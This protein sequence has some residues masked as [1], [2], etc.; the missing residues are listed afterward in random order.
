MPPPLPTPDLAF[1]RHTPI[2]DTHTPSL[3]Q[4]C[5]AKADLSLVTCPRCLQQGHVVRVC[6]VMERS[7]GSGPV[8][9]VCVCVPASV[10]ACM[11][12]CV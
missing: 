7:C 2:H 9:C 5:P 1:P 8:L 3:S 6:S 10:C 4:K 11:C 12:L